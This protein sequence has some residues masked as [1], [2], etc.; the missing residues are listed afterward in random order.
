M[1]KTVSLLLL[2]T[3]LLSFTACGTLPWDKEDDKGNDSP[4]PTDSF[5]LSVG[6][7]KDG[8][9]ICRGASESAVVISSDKTVAEVA[10]YKVEGIG[11]ISYKIIAHKTGK[12][13]ISVKSAAEGITLDSHTYTVE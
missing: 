4:L 7:T 11:S 2:I 3:V 8:A 6:E 1:K 5:T 10:S 12:V 13:T 9:F